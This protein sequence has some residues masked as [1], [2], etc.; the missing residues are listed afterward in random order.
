[1]PDST[2]HEGF[3]PYQCDVF[4]NKIKYQCNNAA[5]WKKNF[6][7]YLDPRKP[8]VKSYDYFFQPLEKD[9]NEYTMQEYSRF[10]KKCKDPEVIKD[11]NK[12]KA[13]FEYQRKLAIIEYDSMRVK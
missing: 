9:A 11:Y 2:V 7:G 12:W 4:N 1:M 6:N 10:T 3:H 5:I 8:E 13:M